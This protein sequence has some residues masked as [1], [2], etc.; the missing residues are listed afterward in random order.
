[1]AKL[2]RL[3]RHI[4]VPNRIVDR[5]FPAETQN[6]VESTVAE[7]E[8]THDVF[9]KV[10]AEARM[11]LAALLQGQTARQRAIELFSR[12]RVW[13][14]EH[15]CGVLIYVQLADKQ[16]EIVA[17]RGINA[18]VKQEEWDAICG[19]IVG[20]FQHGRFKEGAML[21]GQGDQGLTGDS[22][23]ASPLSDP[24]CRQARIGR[25]PCFA[26]W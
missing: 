23:T 19:R 12:L 3:L 26:F 13:D 25:K 4:L 15:N 22:H 17:D 2:G 1:M 14:T 24:D 11:P 7:L 6:T 10:L 20:E 5:A 8:R 18:K 16:V 21:G 9:L